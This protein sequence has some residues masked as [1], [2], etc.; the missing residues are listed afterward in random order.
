MAIITDR[1]LMTYTSWCNKHG[2]KSRM[3]PYGNE[4][5][6]FEASLPI[7]IP[8][9]ETWIW[10]R[11][12]KEGY[13]Y[14]DFVNQPASTNVNK[15]VASAVHL[16][17]KKIVSCEEITNT[18][19]VFNTTLEQVKICGDQSNLSGV[20]HSILH[21]FNYSPAEV[22]FPGWVR[23]GTFFNERNPWWPYFK[24][25][26][27]YKARIST[28]L[29]ETEAFADIAVLHPLADMWTIHGP[30][31]DPFHEAV[32]KGVTFFDTAEMIPAQLVMTTLLCSEK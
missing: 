5:H 11:T 29:Q 22:P 9:C 10:G 25:W 15:F 23:Y 31:R 18:T 30:Q 3:Q 14:I 17:G 21:G 2:F 6:P 8:E 26:S 1:F 7:D 20:N 32:E 4:F 24:Q 27:A 12:N 16:A 19:L 13:T 28:I